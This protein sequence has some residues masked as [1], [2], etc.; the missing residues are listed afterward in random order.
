MLLSYVISFGGLGAVGMH[1]IFDGKPTTKDYICR[2]INF[3]VAALEADNVGRSG[4]PGA[5]RWIRWVWPNEG[6][7]NLKV[8][9]GSRGNPGPSGFGCLFRGWDGSWILRFQGNIVVADNL[10]AELKVV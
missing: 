7:T 3:E 9:G 10:L 6:V 8:D 4:L 2:N 1:L 5:E